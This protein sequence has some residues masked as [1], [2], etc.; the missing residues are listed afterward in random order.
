[1]VIR[2]V[3]QGKDKLMA[4]RLAGPKICSP[5]SVNLESVIFN[6]ILIK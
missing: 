1:M 5:P 4:E 2:Y 3:Y 6:R